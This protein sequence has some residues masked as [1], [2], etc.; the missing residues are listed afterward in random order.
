M[1]DKTGK[2]KDCEHFDSR[3]SFCNMFEIDTDELTDDCPEFNQRE[4]REV[5]RNR[6]E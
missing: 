3:E 2:C 5:Q 1:N 6:F 4:T